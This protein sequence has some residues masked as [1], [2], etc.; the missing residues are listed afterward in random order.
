MAHEKNVEK[1]DD[2]C[3]LSKADIVAQCSST[4]WSQEGSEQ[5]E[6]IIIII[7]NSILR[8]TVC[9]LCMLQRLLHSQKNEGGYI[10]EFL[11][12]CQSV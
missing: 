11:K 1:A 2:E 5:H 4:H 9:K 7:T 6:S 10:N 3:G 12:A 8:R